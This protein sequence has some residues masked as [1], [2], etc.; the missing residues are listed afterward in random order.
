MGVYVDPLTA[1]ETW[2]NTHGAGTL[3]G[4]GTPLANGVHLKRVRSPGQ[5]A[6]ALAT[7]IGTTPDPSEAHLTTPLLSFSVYATEEP[8]ARRAA[9]ALANWLSQAEGQPIPLGDAILACCDS[10]TGPLFA[11]DGGE[12]RYLVDALMTFE[13]A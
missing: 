10:I 13:P 7:W 9:I 12:P 3:V 6:W 8:C 1:V 4:A 11:P 5:G 2:I